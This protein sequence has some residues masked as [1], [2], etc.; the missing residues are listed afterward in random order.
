MLCKVHYQSD[1]EELLNAC[2]GVMYQL[3]EDRLIK[4][5]ASDL[6]TRDFLREHAPDKD[7]FMMHLIAMG[8]QETFGPNK[9]ADGF[10]KEALEKFAH[11]FVTNACL[12]REHRNQDQKTQG[13]GTV[14]AAAYSP[15]MHR[16]E[17][18]VHGHREKAAAEYEK[19]KAGKA[20]SYSMSCF[21]G[22]ALIRM[23]D[24]SN[25]PIS[26]VCVG[27]SVITHKGNSGVVSHTMNREYCESGIELDI[28]GL[29]HNLV[30]T[31]E[32]PIWVRPSA[33]SAHDCPVCGGRFKVLRA[34][35]RQ[36]KD[37]QHKSAYANMS[38]Y[39]EGFKR[40]DQIVPGDHIRVPINKTVAGDIDADLAWLLGLYLAEGHIYEYTDKHSYQYVRLDL[41]LGSHETD[42]AEKARVILGKHTSNKVTVFK[43]NNRNVLKVRLTATKG[44]DAANIIYKLKEWG[45]HLG[46]S[47]RLS[48]EALQFP[49][50]KQ[51]KIVEGWLDGDGAWSKANECIVGTTTSRQL[52]QH[53][54]LL[55]ARCGLPTSINSHK[56]PDRKRAY[57]LRFPQESSLAI[58]F[59]RKPEFWTPSESTYTI[60][61]QHLRHQTNAKTAVRPKTKT[62]SYVDKDNGHMYLRVRAVRKVFVSETVYDLTV[63][64]DHSFVANDVAVSNCRVPY[65]RCNICD[66]RAKKASLYCDHLKNGM[67]QY[68]P[69]FKKYA[70]AINDE[71]TFFDISVVEKPA[72][73]IAHYL[74]YA[75]PDEE[76]RQ[77]AA[78]VSRVISGSQWADYAGLSVPDESD[79]WSFRK[80]AV[81]QK[82][83][84]AEKY[85]EDEHNLRKAANT[86]AKA[87]FAIRVAPLAFQDPL[88]DEAIEAFR[89]VEPGELCKELAKRACILPFPEFAAWVQGT[90]RSKVL[91]D[92]VVKTA[93]TLDLPG[94]MQK[95]MSQGP[96]GMEGLFDSS[97]GSGASSTD[98]VQR[99]MDQAVEK[100]SIK[101]QPTKQ[102]V[103]Q[104]ITIK[105]G[106]E[107]DKQEH[108]VTHIPF[109]DTAIRSKAQAL[110]EAYGVYKVAAMH[111]ISKMYP[112]DVDDLQ[113]LLA[114]SQNKCIYY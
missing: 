40:A 80:L 23:A 28:Y 59:C 63:P 107:F 101:T 84:E 34:H 29:P 26:E 85:M 45:G 82:L 109:I 88:S 30:A 12:F 15:T 5:A 78:S 51:K 20:L 13:I 19:A 10:P 3:I 110:A 76:D 65:D 44:K 92:D 32:H 95:L 31:S 17:I 6:F 21:P 25:K 9:N 55:M 74:E 16:V 93:M 94:I 48:Q 108:I 87:S 105:M 67:L 68:Y 7:H 61:V 64:G 79:V 37:I 18:I 50:D 70:F 89:T 22:S 86:D 113:Y 8:D 90:P 97:C 14:K 46:N 52:V 54:Q 62:L 60:S 57:A 72:D 96:G 69:E 99:F 98:E 35:L 77:K 83:V 2:G 11:T 112:N 75:F 111:D 100:F 71:P 43:Q 114:I 42:I 24:G 4:S 1:Q 73:R 36:K 27:D 106:S 104:I 53:M 39:C 41:T 103:I 56:R 81:L 91:E 49:Y 102:R 58:D 66:N 38:V 47:K 33:K